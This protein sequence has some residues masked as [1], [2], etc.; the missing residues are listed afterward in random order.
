VT[1]P[2]RR[3]GFHVTAPTG[4][5]NDPL[6]VTWHSDGPEEP[7]RY[8]LFVQYNPK[9]AEW[10]PACH[11]GQLRSRDLVRWEW[12]GTA[13]SPGA[14]EDGC[15]SGSVVVHEGVPVIVY[16]SVSVPDL[17][18][19]RIALAFGEPEWMR[20][21]SDEPGPVLSGPPPEL[22]LS[23][24]RDPFVW[25]EDDG[26]RM[27]VGGGRGSGPVAVQY[28]SPDLRNWAFDGI[29]AERPA[30]APESGAVWECV[31][32]FPLD[33]AWVLL[34]SVWNDGEPRRMA[35]AVGEYDGRRFAPRTWQRFTATDA[36]YAATAFLD[37]GG[38]RCAISWVRE[39]GPPGNDWAGVLTVPV[40]LALERDRIVMAPHPALA[41]ARTGD[42]AALGPTRL[43]QDPLA[44]GPFDPFL[45]GMLTVPVDGGRVRLALV[46]GDAELLVLVVDPDDGLVG[47]RR[48]GRL[49]ERLP[50][51]PADDAE[52]VVRLLVDAD[53]VEV[54]ASGD[55]AVLRIDAVPGQL[56]VVLSGEGDRA[57]LS[58]LVVSGMPS[59]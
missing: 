55:A 28:S 37:A 21:A 15:W 43:G 13:L 14:G 7:G 9:A 5:I 54:F 49:D 47:L 27:A 38:R 18:A 56:S 3:P 42:L 46:A 58:G 59:G 31:Q 20:W 40:V 17:D 57:R 6:G 35:G 2:A 33:G 45:D 22:G 34:V 25:R 29:L 50:A 30:G 44:L 24:F 32:F 4:W 26:W 11:W 48:P 10:A 16:T 19:G 52:L 53:L 12:M 36:G 41:A 51:A 39:S 23:H 1:G 8:E